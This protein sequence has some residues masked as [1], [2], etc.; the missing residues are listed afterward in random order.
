MKTYLKKTEQID[1]QII[2]SL[3]SQKLYKNSI[4]VTRD[5][6]EEWIN[7]NAFKRSLRK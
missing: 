3:S 7:R 6:E 1:L 4:H 2:I 5:S